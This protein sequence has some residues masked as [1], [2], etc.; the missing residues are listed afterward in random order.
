MGGAVSPAVVA[1][2]PVG[3]DEPA[4]DLETEIPPSDSAASRDGMASQTA[5]IGGASV[6]ARVAGDIERLRRLLGGEQLAWL[7]DRARRRM[8][9]RQPLTGVVTLP[10]ASHEQRRAA[11]RLLGRRA[12]R[13]YSLSVPLDEVDRI[14]RASGAA[15]EGLAAAV[16]LLTGPVVDEAAV[17]AT[18]SAVWV[19]ARAPLDTF[20]SRRPELSPFLAWL[21]GTGALRRLAGD[22]D[23]AAGLVARLVAV[24]DALPSG[25]VAL[26]G[27]A[28]AATGDAHALDDGRPLATLA[29]AAVR[30]LAGSEPAGDASAAGRRAAWAAVGVHL[31][32]LTSTV[33]CLGLPG[34]T[35]DATGRVLAAAHEAGEPCV[36]TLRQV[37]GR[38]GER[39][40]LGVGAGLVFVCQQPIVLASA[41]DELGPGTPPLVCV[42]EHPSA[43][44]LG[45]LELLAAQGASFAYHG[46]F[47]WAALRLAGGLRDRV[48]W[49]PWRYDAEAYAAALALATATGGETTTGT[50]G[51]ATPEA[52]SGTTVGAG[53]ATGTMARAVAGT[54][55]RAA[56]GIATAT[57]G[58]LTG[59]PVDA[60]WDPAL[61]PALERHGIRVD[62]ELVLRTLL[63]DLAAGVPGPAAAVPGGAAPAG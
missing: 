62:E 9:Q 61:R 29:L 50:G 35:T 52:G 55:A 15:P 47:D 38:G 63:A 3:P 31:D 45:L 7:V 20:T 2:G 23:T 26:D 39:A 37:I 19:A 8:A 6:P 21:D 10:K 56:A 27:L 28:A 58:P 57:G 51:E 25:G 53:T 14:L 42:G 40:A 32:E 18:G 16:V 4:P 17:P 24:L 5:A 54:V 49:R 60:S 11:E 43:A 41:A 33:L 59:R 44:V 34:G 12:G 22:P 36:L 30:V 1:T 46:D 13:G 48:G